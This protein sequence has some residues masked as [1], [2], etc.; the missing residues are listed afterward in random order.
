[1]VISLV[2]ICKYP[3][4]KTI[5]SPFFLNFYFQFV[6][7]NSFSSAIADDEHEYWDKIQ[8]KMIKPTEFYE[9]NA[10]KRQYFYW[11]DL[12]GR[13]FLEDCLPK[14]I[15]TSLKSNGFLNFFTSRIEMN[16]T[17]L[18]EDYPWMSRCGKELNFIKSAD[19][20]IVF[21]DWVEGGKKLVF[22]GDLSIPF[23]PSLLSF[24]LDKGRLYHD[25]V[26]GTKKNKSRYKGR[27]LLHP[28]IALQL[29]NDLSFSHNQVTLTLK[30]ETIDIPTIK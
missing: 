25:M 23:H 22:G 4:K 3:K 18:H 8:R 7:K 13:L 24:N 6:Q 26:G 11:V 2:S 29:S 1:M 20:P 21:S 5:W 28:S 27:C 16:T 17:S 19:T 14:I 9:E 12:R 30:G 10:E 15:S